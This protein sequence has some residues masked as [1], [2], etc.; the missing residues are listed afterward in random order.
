MIQK[1]LVKIQK[2]PHTLPVICH[3][4]SI[5]IF[6][7]GQMGFFGLKNSFSPNINQRYS[8]KIKGVILE[9]SAGKIAL[10]FFFFFFLAFR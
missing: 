6:F 7:S 2:Q 3:F 1:I 10:F 4:I 8:G 5:Y 9:Y